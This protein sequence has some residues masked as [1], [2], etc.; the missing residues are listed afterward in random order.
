MVV[1]DLYIDESYNDDHTLCIGGFLAPRGM[2]DAIV[3]PWRER[4]EYEN[5]QSTKKGFPLIR[6]YHATDCEGGNKE[7]SHKKGWQP[8]RRK[9]L[10]RR[11]C[12]IIS[13]TGPC[14]IVVGGRID[15]IKQ[16]IDPKTDAAKQT[17]YDI[18]F[19]M[20]LLDVGQIMTARFPGAT[21]RVVFDDSSYGKYVRRAFRRTKEDR[22]SAEMSKLFTELVAGDSAVDVELQVADLLAYEG[23]KLLN[24]RKTD[25]DMRL[26]LRK[27]LGSKTPIQITR[28]TDENFKDVL[29]MKK[30]TEEGRSLEEGVTSKLAVTVEGLRTI[31]IVINNE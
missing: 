19:R 18:C 27:L 22:G 24:D 3:K 28:F 12:E 14:G 25:Q 31:G 7:F 17:L 15:E 20:L 16:Y 13:T 1:W 26:W 6:R 29:R 21:V 11:M 4:L 5:R 23:F 10:A 30:N 9:L 2:W 8:N